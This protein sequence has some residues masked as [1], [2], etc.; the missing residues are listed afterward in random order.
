MV[1][2]NYS[3]LVLIDSFEDRFEYL[4]LNG[5]VG[6]ETFGYDRFLN[7][8][9]YH[10]AEWRKFRD[11][12]IIRDNGCDLGVEGHEIISGTILIHHINPI[13]V[14]DILERRPCVFDKNNVISCSLNTH[15]AIHYG[16]A[17]LIR[18]SEYIERKPNDTSPWKL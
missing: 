7:Q 15:N 6:N 13:S 8:E 5:M 2:K 11:E 18:Q 3:D 17:D 12:I 16:N 14:T 10:S 1:N 9:L 4:K